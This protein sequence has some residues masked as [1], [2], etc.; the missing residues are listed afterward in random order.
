MS[1]ETGK[2]NTIEDMV[3]A[4]R[5]GGEKDVSSAVYFFFQGKKQGC[6]AT[7]KFRHLLG[8]HVCV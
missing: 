5:A 6:H 4:F 1:E 2:V 7:L 8:S 3:L